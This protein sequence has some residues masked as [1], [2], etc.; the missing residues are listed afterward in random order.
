MIVDRVVEVLNTAE[1][2]QW[3]IGKGPVG[4]Q[5]QNRAGWQRVGDRARRPNRVDGNDVRCGIDRRCERQCIAIWVRVVG[6][7]PREGV[8]N[9]SRI[10]VSDIHIAESRWLIE[11]G[12][13]VNRGIGNTGCKGAVKH[14]NVD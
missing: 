1:I 11:N 4:I 10:L 7:K 6:Q 12:S 8:P 9:Q 3:D 14:L 5:C 13:K 2:G